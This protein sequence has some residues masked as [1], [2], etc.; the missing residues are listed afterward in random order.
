MLITSPVHFDTVTYRTLLYLQGTQQ[1]WSDEEILPFAYVRGQN[2]ELSMAND[3]AEVEDRAASTRDGSRAEEEK[4]EEEEE[5]EEGGQGQLESVLLAGEYIVP[6]RSPYPSYHPDASD[7]AS[8]GTDKI[9]NKNKNENRD[10]SQD[11]CTDKNVS[12]S[13]TAAAVAIEKGKGRGR[14]RGRGKKTLLIGGT[15]EHALT[16]AELE[17]PADIEKASGLL[18]E[19]MLSMY[20]ALLEEGWKPS[21][22]IAGE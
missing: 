16:M 15:H 8:S 7:D 10:E 4:E 18:M 20:P 14:G 2:V 5:E 22:C 17:A 1:L 13:A 9:K 11:S 12:S 3:M 19:K 6:K 21:R